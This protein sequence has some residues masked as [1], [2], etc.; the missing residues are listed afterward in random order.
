MPRIPLLLHEIH[1][2]T[3]KKKRSVSGSQKSRLRDIFRKMQ[4]DQAFYRT[5]VHTSYESQNETN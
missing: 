5:S 1:P 2:Y 4:I 3:N